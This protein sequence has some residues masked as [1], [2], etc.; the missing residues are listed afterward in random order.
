MPVQRLRTQRLKEQPHRVRPPLS[1][2]ITDDVRAS[3]LCRR[4]SPRRAVRW[5]AIVYHSGR[6]DGAPVVIRNISSGGLMLENAFGLF[7]REYV[8]VV[9]L[10]GRVLEGQIMWALSRYCGMRFTRE[11]SPDDPL[12]VAE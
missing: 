2:D 1:L 4:S 12:N 10:S 8:R 11:L 9:L 7:E 3:I 5:N 6:I